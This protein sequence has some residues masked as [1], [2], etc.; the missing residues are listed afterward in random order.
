ME[1]INFFRTFIQNFSEK[2][3]PSLGAWRAELEQQL[4]ECLKLSFSKLALVTQQELDTQAELLK[5]TR[6]KIEVLQER[7]L[8][9]EQNKHGTV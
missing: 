3:P 2:L 6:N 1:T 4:L 9:L 7:I 5:R 8:K